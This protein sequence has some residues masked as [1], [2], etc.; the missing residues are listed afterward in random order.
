MRSVPQVTAQE[1][2]ARLG[3]KPSGPGKWKT[4]CPAH[5]DHNP[6]LSIAEGD[7]GLVLLNCGAGC[8]FEAVCDALG[9][10]VRSLMGTGDRSGRNGSRPRAAP[11]PARRAEPSKPDA[12]RRAAVLKDAR[13]QV[14]PLDGSAGAEYLQGRGFDPEQALGTR[15]IADLS[16]RAAVCWAVRDLERRTVALHGRHTGAGSPKCH[17]LGSLSDGA[18]WFPSVAVCKGAPE[19]ALVEAPL[20][21]IALHAAT[22][23]PV[24]ALC[25]VALRPWLCEHLRGKRALLG[26]DADDAGERAAAE[27][28]AALRE[29]GAEPL[30]L[31]PDGG[32]DW[33]E[34]L[35]KHGAEW[36]KEHL[37]EPLDGDPNPDA[38]PE[39]LPLCAG[40]EPPAFPLGAL[41][42][43][44]R[45]F[46][47]AVAEHTQT[48]PD[49][50][51]L[52]SLC[53]VATACARTARIEGAPGWT[54]PLNLFV[55]VALPSG[56]RKSAVVGECA[57]P[58]EESERSQGEALRSVIAEN[59]Q[60]RAILK[61]RA[62][63]LTRTAATDRDPKKRMQAAEEAREAA[64]KLA[65]L[66]EEREPRL[67]TDDATPEVLARLMAEQ[68]GRI[69]CLSAEGAVTFE[70][71]AGRYS[72]TGARLEVY[73]Q[74]H[75]GDSLRIDRVG[76]PPEHVRSPALTLCLSVQPSVL[77]GLLSRPGFRG[78]GLL[79][80]FVWSVPK[81][82][83][84][85]RSL[86]APPVPDRVRAAYHE[87]LSRLLRRRPCDDPPTLHV[88][89]EAARVFRAFRQ[90]AERD[91][92]E[93]GRFE[94]LTDWGSKLPGLVLRI[95]G[96]MHLAEH[97][98]GEPVTAQT[99]DAALRIGEYAAEHAILSFAKMGADPIRPKAERL[100]RWI[101]RKGEPEFTARDAYHQNR[102]HFDRPG[103]LTPALDLLEE[104]G[105]LRERPRTEGPGRPSRRFDV[106]PATLARNTRN[107]QN[108][109]PDP[110][111]GHFGRFVQGETPPN[112]AEDPDDDVRRF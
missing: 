25:G 56:S 43:A 80:R 75:A 36:L 102:A 67:L 99:I 86:D 65:E 81:P 29:A 88:D 19:L 14:R 103:D 106:S 4:L 79:A 38:W 83:L 61:S 93:G 101:I 91:L 74:A 11:V 32:K 110:N 57:A 63:A 76:R 97:A 51:G 3:A 53:A 12:E 73:L 34:L 37:P 28:A 98:D 45:D 20:D 68:H 16:G 22:G 92:R 54:E 112:E 6:S 109:P 15:W 47:A 100:L 70:Q 82:T 18:V 42:T 71:A 33:A 49:L 17:T 77:E 62:D 69:A 1:L 40:P 8:T 21:G 64:A 9:L 84:G 95:A 105:Y 35:E 111:T 52:L 55:C 87:T 66:P 10:D 31:R 89:A 48:P 108:P 60:E 41:P 50:P 5:D 59:R 104:L 26:F 72:D 23:K 78:R 90:Q 7:H 46:S 44:L 30:R 27:W 85:H 107:A 39:P 2:A 96:L 13:K 24:A 94:Y 58:I